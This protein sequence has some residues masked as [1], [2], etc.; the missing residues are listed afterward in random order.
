MDTV[1]QRSNHFIEYILPWYL[2]GLTIIS[3]CIILCRRKSIS[4]QPTLNKVLLKTDNPIQ[5][6]PIHIK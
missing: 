2:I 3:I 4:N 5:Y 6:T 1:D